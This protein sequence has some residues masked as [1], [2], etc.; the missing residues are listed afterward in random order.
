[1]VFSVTY[2]LELRNAKLFIENVIYQQAK[3]FMFYNVQTT[4]STFASKNWTPE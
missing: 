1:M 4:Y 2:Y 3:S